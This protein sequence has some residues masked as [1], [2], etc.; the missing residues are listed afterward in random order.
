[1]ATLKNED[2]MP[3]CDFLPIETD[4]FISTPAEE[5]ADAL[6]VC[7]CRDGLSTTQEMPSMPMSELVAA[8][9][10]KDEGLVKAMW[11]RAHDHIVLS[12]A[13]QVAILRAAELRRTLPEVPA[14]D[15]E[16]K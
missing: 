13:E 7:D 11:Q 6:D 14:I 5:I 9:T 4:A 16:V 1:M 10:F 3:G 15:D 8:S 2:K 12:E